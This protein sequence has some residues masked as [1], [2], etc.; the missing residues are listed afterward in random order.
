MNMIYSKHLIDTSVPIYLIEETTYESWLQQ[1]TSEHKTFLLNSG[2]NAK[3]GGFSL[4]YDAGN[5]LIKIIVIYAHQQYKT[6]YI[7]ALSLTLPEGHYHLD[8]FADDNLVHL[9]WGMGAYQFTR[10]KKACRQPANLYLPE[11][12]SAVQHRLKAI[13]L[14][15]DLIN[16][17]TVDMGPVQLAHAAKELAEQF[18]AT[19][20]CVDNQAELEEKFPAVY[21]VGKGS[22]EQPRLI[23]FSWGKPQDPKITLIG[24]GVCFDTGGLDLKPSAGM[25]LMKKDMGGAANVLGLASYLMAQKLPVR[26]RVIIPAVENSTSG[27]AMRPGDI[28]KMRNGK[29][30]EID[31]TDAEGRLV[32]AD[33]IT[34]A[35]EDEQPD[36]LFTFA[37]LTGAARVAV[38]TEIGAYFCTNDALANDFYKDGVETDDPVWRLPLYQPY[39]R[40][41][42]S[43]CADIQNMGYSM[44]GAITAALF[45]EEFFVS[46]PHWLHLD[47]MAWNENV[48]PGHPTGGEAMGI[49]AAFNL[50]KAHI[51]GAK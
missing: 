31:N 21:T 50:I 41:I 36:L 29:T 10:Y 30:V 27:N 6:E 5:R 33:A 13:Y 19:Y 17:P 23:D 38:G 49:G 37:T 32:L 51:Q 45:L 35:T 14:V 16:T 11:N 15:R 4:L 47:I 2:F 3:Q 24:K 46:K 12:L 25:R 9:G 20:S 7:A 42:K 26:L 18:Q 8:N 48:R 40:S 44:G 39:K 22:V 43:S 1:Q 34:Y 28:I